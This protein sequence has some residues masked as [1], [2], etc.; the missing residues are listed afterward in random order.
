MAAEIASQAAEDAGAD[1]RALPVVMGSAYGEIRCALDMM[2]SFGGDIGLPSPTLF[3]NSVHNTAAAYL[4]MATGNRSFSTTVAAGLETPAMALLESLAFLGC[5][6]GRVLLLLLDEPVPLPFALD[7][8]YPPA[9]VGLVLASDRGPAAKMSIAVPRRSP[10]TLPRLPAPLAGHPI[11][12]GIALAMAV[13]RR[14][15]GDVALG[16]PGNGWAIEVR[17]LVE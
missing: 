11:A 15:S 12:G 8:P 9:G 10:G 1:M 2:R 17:D 14:Q 7:P 4:S 3:H 6:R 16:P 5:R 13:A